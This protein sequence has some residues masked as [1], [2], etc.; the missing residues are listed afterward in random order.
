M[1]VCERNRMTQYS[2]CSHSN[3]T[4]T[5]W[6]C[7]RFIPTFWLD[8]GI[9]QLISNE[10]WLRTQ[11]KKWCTS[12]IKLF[13]ILDE[14]KMSCNQTV[15]VTRVNASRKCHYETRLHNA[16]TEPTAQNTHIFT[17]P[18]WETA[19]LTITRNDTPNVTDMECREL[20]HFMDMSCLN[21]LLN[22][23]SIRFALHQ[24]HPTNHS[25]VH[26]HSSYVPEDRKYFG[27]F[28]IYNCKAFK[29]TNLI[30]LRNERGNSQITNL[31]KKN[32]KAIYWCPSSNI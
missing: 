31:K 28:Q 20:V 13:Q 25:S 22:E 4:C 14:K 1:N 2:T 18:R 23:S 15:H 12:R 5:T 17:R 6:P 27:Y 26:R 9:R 11:F 10:L 3:F 30:P 16:I 24:T 21:Q 32:K 29:H 7:L 8:T 19:P